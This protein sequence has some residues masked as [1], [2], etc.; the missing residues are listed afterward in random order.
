[1]ENQ[2]I[3]TVE[4]LAKQVVNN[5]NKV[6]NIQQ[7]AEAFQKVSEDPRYRYDQVI[8][9]LDGIFERMAQEDPHRLMSA[10]EIQGYYD[11]IITLNPQSECKKIFAHLFPEQSDSVFDEQKQDRHTKTAEGMRDHYTSNTVREIQPKDGET[12]QSISKQ[13]SFEV[14]EYQQIETLA[15]RAEGFEPFHEAIDSS[16]IESTLNYD[17]ALIQK[18]KRMVTS[19]FNSIG[20]SKIAVHVN[21]QQSNDQLIPTINYKASVEIDGKRADLAVLVEIKN[22]VPLFPTKFKLGKETFALTAEGLSK[23][24]K[25]EGASQVR[26]DGR[27][28][29]MTYNQL[30]KELH[31]AVYAKDTSKAS[32]CLNLISDKFGR[33]QMRSALQDYQDAL[34]LS[35]VDHFEQ[36]IGCS[37]YEDP[38]RKRASHVMDYCNKLSLPCN[39]VKMV[40]GS[41]ATKDNICV[42]AD[43]KWDE[44]NDDA[45]KG[46]ISTSQISM[47]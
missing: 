18:G 11:H 21:E 20:I 32:E 46:Q 10:Y 9:N 29:D 25:T 15:K 41:V 26:Y 16:L 33:E 2:T 6:F 38:G 17:R 30:L 43:V 19:E 12:P 45:Y 22:N 4:A 13:A 5:E 23:A 36:C 28:L 3:A 37:Y 7:I 39:R 42:K 34:I 1:M 44:K 35:S 47:T 14:D 24:F 40:Q 8:R 31:N 27:I